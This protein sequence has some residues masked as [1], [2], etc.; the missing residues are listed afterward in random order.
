MGL[1][2]KKP[3]I[4]ISELCGKADVEGCGSVHNHVALGP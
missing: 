3:K 1:F 2:S 4:V